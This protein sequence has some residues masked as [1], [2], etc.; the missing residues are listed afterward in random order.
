MIGVI[1]VVRKTKKANKDKKT[2]IY[3]YER[4]I[5][6]YNSFFYIFEQYH[7]IMQYNVIIIY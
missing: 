6:I 5:I 7:Y 3:N 1:M 2:I 4:K